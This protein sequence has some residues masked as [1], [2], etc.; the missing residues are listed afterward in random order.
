MAFAN[1]VNEPS[2][3]ITG[4]DS[5]VIKEYFEGMRG[6]K[7]LDVTGFSPSVI[8]AG[9][10][11]IRAN[12]GGDFKPMPVTGTGAIGTLGAITGGS[13]Y[14][15]GTHSNI[16]LTGGSGSGA[17]ADIVVTGGVVTSV[18]IVSAGSSYEAADSLSAANTIIGGGAGSGFA[19]VV[20]TVSAEPTAYAALPASHSYVGILV[21][22]ILKTNPQAAIM[23]RGTVNPNVTPYSM[24]SI[25]SAFVTA[26][27]NNILFRAD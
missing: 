5:I 22:S 6:G 11:I 17:T 25:Q 24:S 2:S 12:S 21:A 13:G 10:V 14:E 18:T 16:A 27:G 7:T 15:D 23:V 26:T 8:R 1:L 9:H 19:V 4:N 3:V 20:S